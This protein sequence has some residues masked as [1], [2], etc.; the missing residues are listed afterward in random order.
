MCCTTYHKT[1]YELITTSEEEQVSV[2]VVDLTGK[3]LASLSLQ[4]LEDLQLNLK[5][6][7]GQAYDR[8]AALT[9][10]IIDVHAVINDQCPKK[11]QVHTV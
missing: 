4:S 7:V 8:T 11:L 6:I 9:G 5:K 3:S 10:P 2:S 1:F